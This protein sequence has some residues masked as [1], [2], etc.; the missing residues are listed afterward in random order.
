MSGVM[1]RNI[2]R[3]AQRVDVGRALAIEA[4]HP[5][6]DVPLFRVIAGDPR[7]PQLPFHGDSPARRTALSI[8]ASNPIIRR[9]LLRWT[10]M[11]GR[12]EATA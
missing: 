7:N 2:R 8:L 12:F 11:H 6:A 3:V 4:R 10:R 5:I 1:G 9:R